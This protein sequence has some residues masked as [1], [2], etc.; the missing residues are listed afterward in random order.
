M[1]PRFRLRAI[2]LAGIGLFVAVACGGQSGTQLAGSQE[3]RVNVTTEPSTFDP[4]RTQW[5]YEAAVDRNVF[6]S[7]LKAS[8]DFKSVDPNAA[9]SYTI[10]STGTVYTFK[11]HSGA[12]WSDG[13]PVTASDFVYGW[14]RIV[15][16]RVA[17]P[18][19]SFYYSVKNASKINGMS[20]KDPTLDSALQSLGVKAVDD[21]TFQVTLEAPAGYFKWVASVWLGAPVR[22][23]I[24]E[25]YGKDSSGTDKWGAVAPTAVESV[26]G[27]GPYKVIE[28]V[29]KD[30]VTLGLNPSYSGNTPKP[31]LTKIVLYEIDDPTVGYA[32][33]KSGELDMVQVPLANV[34]AVRTN[35][36]VV[37]VPELVVYWIDINTRAKPFDNPSVRRAFSLAFDRESYAKN[38]LK[39]TGIA[40]FSLVPKGMR[41]YQP[42]LGQKYDP[43]AAKAELAKSGYTADQLSAMQIKWL[44]NSNSP[45]QKTLSEFIQAQFK[46]NLGVTVVLDGTDSKTISS[47]LGKL[48]YQIGGLSGWGA[49]YPDSQD[50][51]DIFL[52]GSGNQFSGWS[53]QA[54]DA[55]VA[56]GDA[57]TDDAQR[58]AAYADAQRAL[59]D[60]AP[61]IFLEQSIRWWQVKPYVKGLNISPNDDFLGDLSTYTIRLTQH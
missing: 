19:A 11:L 30:H 5:N 16:P 12:K 46:Q 43:T 44:Y 18:Y 23:D 50:W 20:P 31:T 36:E 56:K 8:K 57:A 60:G 59:T 33:Y 1:H 13:K 6:E 42:E 25:K 3:L 26:V 47:R 24:V 14:Q 58:D 51:F 15:D 53:D 41:N 35:P 55:A 22:K 52:T 34:D 49:D 54:Y 7:L 10:D 61:V 4:S 2:S 45:T 40:A 37:K 39:G 9:D 28:V 17:A 21:N 27:N 29:A 48:Q 32:K 38:I